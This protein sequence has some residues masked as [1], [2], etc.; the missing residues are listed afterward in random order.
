MALAFSTDPRP[1]SNQESRVVLTYPV[2]VM[3]PKSDASHDDCQGAIVSPAGAGG[4][5]G[6]NTPLN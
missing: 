1:H 6:R 3:E 2:Q 5:C 4:S